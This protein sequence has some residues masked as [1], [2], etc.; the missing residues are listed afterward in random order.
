M[1]AYGEAATRYLTELVHRRPRGW[2]VDVDRLHE[3]LQSHGAQILREAL[4]E[5]LQAERFDVRFVEEKLQGKL[6]FSEVQG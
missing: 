3:I 2:W 4:E 6:N 1:G 5:G